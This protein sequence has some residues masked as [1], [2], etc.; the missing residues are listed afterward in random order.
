MRRP[1]GLPQHLEFSLSARHLVLRGRL[2]APA[3]FFHYSK[4]RLGLFHSSIA[5]K[6]LQS[7]SRLFDDALGLGAAGFAPVDQ[8][9]SPVAEE[10]VPFLNEHHRLAATRTNWNRGRTARSSIVL[11]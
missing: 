4:V 6:L 9:N 8:F 11:S 7:K 5:P 2:G 1:L 10:N 3:A